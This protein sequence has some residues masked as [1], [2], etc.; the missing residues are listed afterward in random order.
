MNV[1][2]FVSSISRLNSSV[3]ACIQFCLSWPLISEV[4]EP[5][6][7]AFDSAM[8][9]ACKSL[10]GVVLLLLRCLRDEESRSVV[11]CCVGVLGG[12]PDFDS[13]SSRGPLLP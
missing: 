10:A 3:A 5:P 1:I 7:G 9:M 11:V 12:V 2:V 8:L 13:A 4:Y 6:V